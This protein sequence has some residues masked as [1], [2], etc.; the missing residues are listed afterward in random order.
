LETMK[1]EGLS[2]N[3]TAKR[4]NVAVSTVIRLKHHE[5]KYKTYK[6]LKVG[7]NRPRSLAMHQDKIADI[8]SS[9]PDITLSEIRNILLSEGIHVGLTCIYLHLE[10]CN[11]TLKK[12][13]CTPRNKT[14]KMSS[15]AENNGEN[16]KA[17]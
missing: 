8:L 11:L 6:P 15:I 10:R 13:H 17:R 12:R 14:E 16:I 1:K 2:C 9:K 7:G 4:Y 5:A 3:Q